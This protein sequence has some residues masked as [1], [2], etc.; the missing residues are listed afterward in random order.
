MLLQ[1][2]FAQTNTGG[3]Y[4]NQ[5]IV[6][7]ELQCLFQGIP[8]WRRHHQVFICAGGANVGQ[9]LGLGRVNRKVIVTAVQSNNLPFLNI[10]IGIN[11]QTAPIL[12]GEQRVG[13]SLPFHEGHQHT[14][15]SVNNFS[16]FNRAVVVKYVG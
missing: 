15:H 2:F 11:N 9:L 10:D 16:I 12:Q 3:R 6:L 14:I 13:Q 8:N 5:L 4:F 7:N 1:Q